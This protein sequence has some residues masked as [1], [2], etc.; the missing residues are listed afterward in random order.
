MRQRIRN[1]IRKEFLQAFRE[2]RMRAMLFIPPIMQLLIFGYAVN[3]D[4][5][6]ARIAWMDQDQT[7]ESRE[8]LSQF[9][10]SGRFEIVSMPRTDAEMQSVL[11]RSRSGIDGG[12]GST[13]HRRRRGCR[14]EEERGRQRRRDWQ[15]AATAGGIFAVGLVALLLLCIFWFMTG[16][17]TRRP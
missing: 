13:Q 6:S 9:E 12:S 11:D 15:S 7:P 17:T 2:P 16:G 10:G 5:E 3:L 1:I 14:D 8:L 4:V